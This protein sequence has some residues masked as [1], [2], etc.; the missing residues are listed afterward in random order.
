VVTHV[1]SPSCSGCVYK[2]PSCASANWHI[3]PFDPFFAGFEAGEFVAEMGGD[4]AFL[5]LA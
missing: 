1:L 4:V 3:A 2:G 5:H